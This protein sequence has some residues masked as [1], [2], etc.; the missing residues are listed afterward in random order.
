[1]VVYMISPL[2]KSE[3][4]I[5]PD[6][7]TD[8]LIHRWIHATAQPVTLDNDPYIL[9]WSIEFRNHRQLGGL[10]ADYQTISIEDFPDGTAD[11]ALWY[12]TI[13]PLGRLPGKDW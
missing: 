6:D 2:E 9:R 12:R 1:M 13:I 10:Q 8:K 5:H 3:L 11:F 4:R 7:F